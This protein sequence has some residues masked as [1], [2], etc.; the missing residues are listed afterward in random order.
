[1]EN[2]LGENYLDH[3][4]YDPNYIGSEKDRYGVDRKNT[5]HYHEVEN[6][7]V[8]NKSKILHDKVCH[9]HSITEDTCDL[10]G[11]VMAEQIVDTIEEFKITIS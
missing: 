9:L 10:E 4:R 8:I 7:I 1:M 11:L 5:G 3:N 2:N 6:K